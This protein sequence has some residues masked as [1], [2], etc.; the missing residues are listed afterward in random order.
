MALK[1]IT[2]LFIGIYSLLW[3]CNLCDADAFFTTNSCYGM[4]AAIAVPL[5]LPNR[6]IFVS[7]NFEANYN[8]PYTFNIPPIATG[9]DYEDI[10]IKGD[11]SSRQ[12]SQTEVCA[13]C[14]HSTT[15]TTTKPA[16][17]VTSDGR[18][19]AQRRRR[20]KSTVKSL[21]TRTHFYY[22]LKDRFERSGYSGEPCLLRLICETNSSG[23]GEVNGVLGTL[24]HIIFSP[25]T[26]ANEN[27][28]HSYY[29]AEMDGAHGM[30]EHYATEC[31]ENP[32]DLISAPLGDIIDDL[33]GDK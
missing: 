30:C 5:E 32:L 27:L 23:L 29:Q 7:Y 26:S 22:I 4:F 14:T 13:N 31:E 11:Y 10:F 8:L 12:M 28:P 1:Q 21:L 17:N 19:G 15:A 2:G 18:E 33:M 16:A 20:R 6:N 25:S 3:H 24:V 9:V